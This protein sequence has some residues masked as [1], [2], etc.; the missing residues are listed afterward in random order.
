MVTVNYVCPVCQQR[1]SIT[2][3]EKQ[4]A[5]LMFLWANRFVRYPKSHEFYEYLMSEPRAVSL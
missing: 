1:V 5:D 2:L 4:V 3:P